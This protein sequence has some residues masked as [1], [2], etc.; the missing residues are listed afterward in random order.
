MCDAPNIVYSQTFE[1]IVDTGRQLYIRSAGDI[2]RAHAIAIVTPGILRESKH[3]GIHV[4]IVSVGKT[5]P[6]RT[7]RKYFAKLKFL[8]QRYIV[9]YGAVCPVGEVQRTIVVDHQ[10]DVSYV[11]AATRAVLPYLKDGDLFVVESTSPIGTTEA[12]AEIIYAERPELKGKI[13]VA[14]CPER[15]LPGN[16]IYELVHNDRV[17]GGIDETSAK[18]A[19]A[20]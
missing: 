2:K 7:G 3:W 1:Y 8:H 15:V 16:V 10:P 20:F 17:I 11:E 12:M 6:E 9:E 5:T 4:R 14:Y 13:H 19:A 18:K